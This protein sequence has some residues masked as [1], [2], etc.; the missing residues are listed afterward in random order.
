[1]DL[2]RELGHMIA[3]I[4]HLNL[5][6]VGHLL[7]GSLVEHRVWLPLQI[8]AEVVERVLGVLGAERFRMVGANV[9]CRFDVVLLRGKVLLV[10]GR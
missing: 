9:R 6:G 8:V 5:L 4:D 10:H 3:L 7:N 2:L 1:M